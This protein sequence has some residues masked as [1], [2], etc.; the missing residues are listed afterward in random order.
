MDSLAAW[1]ER[2]KLTPRLVLIGLVLTGPALWTGYVVDDL[3]HRATFLG[4]PGFEIFRQSP[5]KMFGFVDGDP[6]RTREFVDRGIYPWWTL[7][8]LKLSFWRPLTTLSHALD[9]ALWPDSAF[10]MH[11]HS[12]LWFAALIIVTAAIYRD[13]L[14]AGWIA[15]LAALLYVIDDA[16]AHPVGWIANRNA[17]IAVVFGFVCIWLHIRW[18]RNGNLRDF[19]LANAALLMALLGNEGGIAATAYLFAYAVCLDSGPWRRRLLSL[20]PYAVIV[21]AWRAVYGLQGYGAYGS[22]VYTDPLASPIEFLHGYLQRTP[23]LLLGQWALPPSDGFFVPGAAPPRVFPVAVLALIVYALAPLLRRDPAARFFF[24]GMA[25]ATVPFAACYPMDRLL[26]FVGL[27]AMGL[28]A[29]FIRA[30][31][32]RAFDADA[33]LVRR[34]IVR[35]LAAVLIA[36]HLVLAPAMLTGRIVAWGLLGHFVRQTAAGAPLDDSSRDKTLVIVDAP[37]IFFTVYLG[38]QRAV[39]DLPAPGRVAHLGPDTW[40]SAPIR[41]TRTDAR[42]LV[43]EPSGSYSFFLFRDEAHPMTAGETI[44]L[45]DYTVSVEAVNASG[46]PTRVV[47]RFNAPLEDKSLVWLY[48]DDHALFTD[49]PR[50]FAPFDLPAIGQTIVM[51][52][53]QSRP[54]QARS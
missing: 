27:G 24:T 39:L 33:S 2:P 15:G 29:Q 10:L 41:I 14:G 13:V 51:N 42:T 25:L 9:Y 36:V 8:D 30:A 1:L 16:R 47:Y 4:V 50:T 18:R 40:F 48:F 38:L 54:I 49:T 26:T 35:P 23:A 17:L 45:T 11:L 34:R 3:Y 21:L 28:T 52:G 32:E 6:E 43:Y 19:V 20:A 46:R 12:L 7:P 22:N 5:F 31:R 53:P 44:T 37:T